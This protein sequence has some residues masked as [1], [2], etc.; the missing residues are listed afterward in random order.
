MLMPADSSSRTSKSAPL[1]SF[2]AHAARPPASRNS[3]ESYLKSLILEVPVDLRASVTISCNKASDD[4]TFLAI[5]TI[6]ISTIAHVSTIAI[7]SGRGRGHNRN[8]N[9]DHRIAHER[10]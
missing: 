8:R 9:R 1:S 3:R 2:S 5:S 10:R 7:S 6:A 4:S